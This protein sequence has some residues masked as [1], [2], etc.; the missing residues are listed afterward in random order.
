MER[1]V[2]KRQRAQFLM[3]NADLAVYRAT[4]ALRIADAAQVA[5]LEQA[6]A[7]FLE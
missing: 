7:H 2:A 6:A 1:A 3:E 4:M 5:E